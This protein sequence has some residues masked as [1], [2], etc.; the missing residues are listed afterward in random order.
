MTAIAF[1]WLQTLAF[2]SSPFPSTIHVFGHCSAY[3]QT[4]LSLLVPAVLKCKVTVSTDV[5]CPL[6]YKQKSLVVEHQTI[7]MDTLKCMVIISSNNFCFVFN[8]TE[9]EEVQPKIIVVPVPVPVFVPV[10]LHLY[11]QYTPVPL[12]MPVPVS[13]TQVH[14]GTGFQFLF[15]SR[16]MWLGFLMS[17]VS[18]IWSLWSHFFPYHVTLC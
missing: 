9:E 14:W 11:T 17:H 18:G 15:W 7:M 5:L 4:I 12:G 13:Y 10:P 16:A 2:I 8:I 3:F 6:N 1:T